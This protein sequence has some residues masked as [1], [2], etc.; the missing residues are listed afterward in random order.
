MGCTRKGHYSTPKNTSKH[1]KPSPK[2]SSPPSSPTSHDCPYTSLSPPSS[3][4]SSTPPLSSIPISPSTTWILWVKDAYK[5]L[6]TKKIPGSPHKLKRD[7]KEWLLVFLGY[8]CVKTKD[9][10]DSF[11]RSLEPYDQ[12]EDVE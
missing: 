9:H 4:T 11:L 12:H 8:D 6:D 1:L 2:W 5:S 7:F 10:L 3:P